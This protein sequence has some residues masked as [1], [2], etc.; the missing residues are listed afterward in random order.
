DY[1]L[2]GDLDLY[3]VSGN[4][5]PDRGGP[6][7]VPPSRGGPAANRLFRN[8]GGGRFADATAEAGVG[9][10]GYGMGAAVGDYDN[11]GRP[12]IY[13]THFT[14]GAEGGNVLF[15]NEGGGKFRDV[16]RAA[17]TASGGW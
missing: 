7:P 1:D 3:C 6:G 2:D 5:H 4:P 8:E 16:A 12:D 9:D 10:G 14:L 17:G 13:V 15:H 11:D